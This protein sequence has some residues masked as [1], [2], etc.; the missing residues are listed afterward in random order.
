MTIERPQ[1]E[2][3][4]AVRRPIVGAMGVLRVSEEEAFDVLRRLSREN[5]IK[6]REVARASASGARSEARAG[7]RLLRHVV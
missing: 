2:R 3:A 7:G 4:A 1:R 6:L 5:T